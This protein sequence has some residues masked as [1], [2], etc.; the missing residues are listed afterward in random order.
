MFCMLAL[1]LAYIIRVVVHCQNEFNS[2]DNFPDVHPM[3][4]TMH[5]I[6]LLYGTFKVNNDLEKFLHSNSILI[7]M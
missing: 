4:A 3:G 1:I 7:Y 5:K 2:H 6:I